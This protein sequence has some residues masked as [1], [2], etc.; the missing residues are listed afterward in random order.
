MSDDEK[1][2]LN[3]G[4]VDLKRI[5]FES[6][7]ESK[8]HEVPEKIPQMATRSKLAPP[9]VKKNTRNKSADE[10]TSAENIQT[11]LLQ[12]K[13]YKIYSFIHLIIS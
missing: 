9:D 1:I 6:P 11:L 7:E 3:Q 5:P 13:V 2:A 12:Q 10:T 8:D 4:Q